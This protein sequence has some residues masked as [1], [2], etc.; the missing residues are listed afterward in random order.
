MDIRQYTGG[1]IPGSPGDPIS[2]QYR[3]V[4]KEWVDAEAAASM[5]EECK[6]PT[7]A[8]RMAELGDIPVNRAET[9]VKASPEWHEY[10]RSMVEARKRANLLKCKLEYVRMRFSEQQSHE[11]TARSERR[12]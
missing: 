4:S 2:E 9:T 8:Q 7:M 3:L 12:L 6:T 5:L 11:A 10:I 1:A